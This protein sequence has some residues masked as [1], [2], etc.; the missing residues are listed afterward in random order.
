MKTPEELAMEYG[1]TP[2]EKDAFLAG[3]Q[4]AKDQQADTSK[5]MNFL[6]KL[7][8]CDHIVDVNKMVDVNYSRW[9]SV[10]ER[11]P[12]EHKWVL[13]YYS[14]YEHQEQFVVGLVKR[15]V[16]SWAG[17]SIWLT[18]IQDDAISYEEVYSITHWMALPELPKEEK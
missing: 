6:K 13:G 1:A 5:V 17:A 4:A 8:S 12:E 2:H 10:K 14:R 11:L 16:H 15:F 3:Y 7:D 18:D 9:I